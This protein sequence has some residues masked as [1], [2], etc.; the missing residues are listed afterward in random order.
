MWVEV[1]RREWASGKQEQLLLRYN[2]THTSRCCRDSSES[3]WVQLQDQRSS[4]SSTGCCC[5]TLVIWSRVR[6]LLLVATL[7]RKLC[8]RV[9]LIKQ[10]ARKTLWALNVKCYF[11]SIEKL[12]LLLEMLKW[13]WL[14][15]GAPPP[16]YPSLLPP[17]PAEKH[18]GICQ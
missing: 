14:K 6:R 12:F 2:W 13:L 15:H 10:G 1:S 9:F 18:L 11:I 16:Y 17:H 4:S 3:C 7:N 5:L 8:S